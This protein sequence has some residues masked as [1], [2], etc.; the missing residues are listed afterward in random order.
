MTF[1]GFTES[2]SIFHVDFLQ[3]SS[4]LYR[5]QTQSVARFLHLG[6]H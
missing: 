4:H 6:G 5:V 2:H 1:R 3:D